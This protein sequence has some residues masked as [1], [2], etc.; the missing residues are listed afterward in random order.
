MGIDEMHYVFDLTLDKVTTHDKAYVEP[1]EKDS[2]INQAINLYINSVYNSDLYT[3]Q[4]KVPEHGGFEAN[5][6][7]IE[8]LSS[9]HIQSPIVQPEI[10]PTREVNGLYEFNL[11]SLGDFVSEDLIPQKFRYMY[12]TKIIIAAK[13]EGCPVRYI[14]LKPLQTDDIKTRYNCA[15]WDFRQVI[16]SFGKSSK[17]IPS[18]PND[19]LMSNDFS[20][21]LSGGVGPT[22]FDKSDELLSLF[23]DST[24]KYGKKEFDVVGAQI[25]YLKYPNSVCLGGYVTITGQA[26]LARVECDINP[27]YHHQIVMMAV[28]LA[29]KA[30]KDNIGVGLIKDTVQN[31][32]MY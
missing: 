19:N 29:T 3:S 23:V 32:D 25:S 20:I 27:N 2:F 30:L 18:I 14:R 8:Q 11:N 10:L 24:D 5:Q 22:R 31:F 21:E 12:A 9:L 17:G 1:W 28:E 7:R 26:P 13:R 4:G 15:N 6:L 16:G